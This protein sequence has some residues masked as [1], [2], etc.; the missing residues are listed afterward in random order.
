MATIIAELA[1]EKE[2]YMESV[3]KDHDLFPH[4]TL[5]RLGWILENIAGEENLKALSDLC[6]KDVAPTF[7]SPY[8]S[9]T[10]EKD[11]KWN[12]IVNR[13]VEADI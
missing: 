11:T 13:K 2:N 8:D 4:A 1:E 3:I 12:I 10:G 9:R 6:S 5:C 7:L